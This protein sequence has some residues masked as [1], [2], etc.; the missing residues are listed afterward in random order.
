M[1]M[2][3][4]HLLEMATDEEKKKSESKILGLA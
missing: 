3:L 1:V 2:A 4:D